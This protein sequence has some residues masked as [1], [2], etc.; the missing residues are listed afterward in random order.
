MNYFLKL[1]KGLFAPRKK[2]NL[3]PIYAKQE[4]QN[5]NIIHHG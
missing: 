4:S 1:L 2:A 3:V 5:P